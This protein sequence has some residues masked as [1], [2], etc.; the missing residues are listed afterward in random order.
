LIGWRFNKLNEDKGR[1]YDLNRRET[2]GYAVKGNYRTQRWWTSQKG[3]KV[4]DVADTPSCHIPI[5]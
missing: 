3:T 2:D 4:A 1:A 5:V